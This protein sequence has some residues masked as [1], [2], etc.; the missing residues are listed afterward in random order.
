MIKTNIKKT[1]FAKLFFLGMIIYLPIANA[2]L[3]TGSNSIASQRTILEIGSCEVERGV[4]SVWN[5]EVAGNL[6]VE[7][8]RGRFLT[9][10][11]DQGFEVIVNDKGFV[12]SITPYDNR[13]LTQYIY[14]NLYDAS[15]VPPFGGFFCS[16]GCT[17]Y[18]LQYHDDD[19]LTSCNG[20]KNSWEMQQRNQANQPPETTISIPSYLNCST[21]GHAYN[22]F[23]NRCMRMQ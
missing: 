6:R 7:F 17:T 12:T 16:Y 3:R 8:S 21:D 1:I 19:A 4:R 14:G 13:V 20:V 9:S 5:D 18:N 2:Q 23:Y 22:I 15:E 10:F 11:K